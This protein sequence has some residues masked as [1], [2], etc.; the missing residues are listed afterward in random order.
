MSAAAMNDLARNAVRGGAVLMAARLAVQVFTWAVTF[1]VARRLAVSDY[2]VMAWALLVVHFADQLAEAGVGR[3]LVQKKE[4]GPTDRDQAF[5]LSLGLGALLYTALFLASAPLAA[6]L[7][8]PEL[9]PLLRVMG[10]LLLIVPFRTVALATLDRE[11][12]FSRQALIVVLKSLAQSALVLSLASAGAGYWALA[13][14]ALLGNAAEAAATLH[15]SRWVPSLA[16]P[17]KE[18]RALVAFGLWASGGAMLW[19]VYSNADFAVVGSMLGKEALG[20]YSFA[21][22]LMSIPV[23]RLTASVNQIA[24][25]VFCRL[26]HEPERLRSWHR[27]LT[28]LLGAI[29]V[30]VLAGMALVADDAFPL[31]LGEKWNP[32]ILPFQLLSLVGILNVLV[33]TLSPLLNAL[34]RPDLNFRY[35]FACAL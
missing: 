4:L 28:T 2:G 24:Y 19:Y 30:P 11:G 1:V 6:S 10:L 32:A 34:G 12:R 3:A 9:V 33:Y 26:Q 16:W 8:V 31:V 18:A 27:R 7:Q 15:A 35:T 20:A 14:G 29:A 5:T 25:P 21:F 13:A 17:G 23:E 22:M